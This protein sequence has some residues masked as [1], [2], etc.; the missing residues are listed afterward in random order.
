MYSYG[1]IMNCAGV[2]KVQ[3]CPFKCPTLVTSCC[4]TRGT[5]LAIFLFSGILLLNT[6]ERPEF[7]PRNKCS[8]QLKI[9]RTGH[10]LTYC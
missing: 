4:A 3:G 5:I 1:T 2:K 10:L 7:T 6:Y 9:V 8:V